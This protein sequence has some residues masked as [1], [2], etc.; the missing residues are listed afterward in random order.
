MVDDSSA[1]LFF[2]RR[3]AKIGSFSEWYDSNKYVINVFKFQN[4]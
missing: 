1:K 2:A 4:N 3:E